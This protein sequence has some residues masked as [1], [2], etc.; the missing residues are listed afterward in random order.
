MER[1]PLGLWSRRHPLPG[2]G[3]TGLDRLRL[4]DL[5]HSSAT[6]GLDAGEDLKTV[7]ERLGH[8]TIK[9]TAD[10]YAHVQE[11]MKRRS[12]DAREALLFGAPGTAAAR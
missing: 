7:S 12:A 1:Q 3:V 5:R 10:T 11:S 2:A 8:S 4:Y 9:L 6:L